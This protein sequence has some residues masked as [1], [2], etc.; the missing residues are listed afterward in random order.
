M[1]TFNMTVSPSTADVAEAVL[2]HILAA[3]RAMRSATAE[4]IDTATFTATATAMD[5]ASAVAPL[6]PVTAAEPA[7]KRGRPAKVQPEAAP[8]TPLETAIADTPEAPASVEASAVPAVEVVDVD[9]A[10]AALAPPAASVADA[11]PIGRRPSPGELL[12]A[13]NAARTKGKDPLALTGAA[14][15]ACNTQSITALTDAVAIKLLADL[16]ALVA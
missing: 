15:A 16:E 9:A 10:L 12:A 6:A 11:A 3:V 8:A 4:M 14:L 5:L 2:G 1:L 7:K 13:V